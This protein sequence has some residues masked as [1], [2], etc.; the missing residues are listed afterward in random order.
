MRVLVTGAAGFVGS[1]V[2]AELVSR[3]HDVWGIDAFRPSY[4]RKR[5]EQFVAL[6]RGAGNWEFEER[7]VGSLTTQ[8]LS[9]V[10]AVVHLAGQADVRESWE[11]FD[12]HVLDNVTE[13]NHLAS[14]VGAA[15]VPRLVYSSTSSVYGEAES[16]P[17][18]ETAPTTPLS[19]YGVSKLA[20]EHL[21]G[22][23]AMLGGYS[24]IAL[25]L[26]TVFGPGQRKGMA[27]ERLI[28]AALTGAEFTMF[29][30]GQQRRDF[31]YVSDVARAFADSVDVALETGIAH[32]N[33]G[34]EADVSIRNLIELIK[35][36][37]GMPIAVNEVAA[38]GGE[39]LRTDAAT[40]KATRILG[41]RPLITLERG[42][43]YQVA[44]DR[45]ENFTNWSAGLALD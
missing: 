15:G 19:P 40:D 5:K 30:N 32:V 26:F 21:L 11:F 7:T 17:V 24:V 42:I 20:G 25:R 37:T 2:V 4:P 36:S 23:H 22:A 1:H 45:E 6:A 41:W 3:G 29:G 14:I 39:P 35:A 27:I 43:A 38:R 44:F 31:V 33:I 34:G 28:N 13:T 10:D 18:G 9:D 16:Y 12:V 8:G